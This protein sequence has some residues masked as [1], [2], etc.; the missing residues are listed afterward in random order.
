MVGDRE[1]GL[2]E[3]L[4]ARD[5]VVDPVRAVEQRVLGVA[6]QVDEGHRAGDNLCLTGV[7]EGNRLTQVS[8]PGN[9]E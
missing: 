9:L 4:G 1:G 8:L 6:V 5:Q 3:L 2:L 7:Y